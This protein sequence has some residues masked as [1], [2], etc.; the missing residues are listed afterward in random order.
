MEHRVVLAYVDP[1]SGYVFLQIL[2][3]GLLGGVAFFRKWIWKTI[4]L[5]TGRGSSEPESAAE[6]KDENQP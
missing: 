1:V 4:G 3:A 6:P 5:I 2:V